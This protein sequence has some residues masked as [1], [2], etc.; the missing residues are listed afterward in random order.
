MIRTP[1]YYQIGIYITFLF[2][3]LV[4]LLPVSFVNIL[5]GFGIL[6]LGILHGAN[7]IEIISKNYKGKLKNLY[8]KSIFMYLAV[9]LLG[10]LFFFTLPGLALLIFVLFSSYHFGEQHW[11]DRLPIS[12]S[13]FA[14]Y[15][16]YGGFIFFLM[17]ILQ[18][19]TV[20]EV[21]DKI[22]GYQLGFDFFL[23]TG[24]FLG[25]SL[26]ITMLIMSSTRHYFVREW[27]LLLF[28]GAIFYVGS[29]LFAFA[30]YFVVWHSF[31]SLL[32][33]LKFLY[34]EM[35]FKSFVKY[36]KSS[37]LYWL[38]S[39]VSLLLVYRYIDFEAD[40]FMPLFF[41]FLAAITFPHTVVIGFM[42]H[43]ND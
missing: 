33:Q 21:V 26:F 13:H 39:L 40:Y 19:D 16:L 22:T 37:F 6:T 1:K 28:L 17:F 18:Y 3:V 12:V 43:K 32:D 23:Y 14:F 15:T 27:I 25:I 20:A 9:V 38:S 41:S 7:D 31:P 11:E 2:M 42:K 8:L 5:W 36:L 35:N 29:L 10:A 30:F 34:G 24:V 4:P